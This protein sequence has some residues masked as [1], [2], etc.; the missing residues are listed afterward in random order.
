M[1]LPWSTTE[2]V[3]STTLDHLRDSSNTHLLQHRIPR[4]FS[5]SFLPNSSTPELMSIHQLIHHP[6]H[7]TWLTGNSRIDSHCP[8]D[9]EDHE[10]DSRGL[11]LS[12][13]SSAT[14]LTRSSAL[15]F[16]VI[17]LANL[18]EATR[19]PHTYTMP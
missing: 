13:P 3:R 10:K 16:V 15:Y 7:R 18:A 11:L 14:N 1:F 5:G 17:S 6:G 19:G 9:L 8:F 4:V 2:N 12:L